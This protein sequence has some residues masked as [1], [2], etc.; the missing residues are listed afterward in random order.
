MSFCDGFGGENI[1]FWHKNPLLYE[2][3]EFS[4]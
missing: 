1:V 3:I 4:V 2:D